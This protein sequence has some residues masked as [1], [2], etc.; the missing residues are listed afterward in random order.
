[1][2]AGS[3]ELCSLLTATP[4]HRQPAQTIQ[5]EGSIGE[6][7]GE[8]N[9]G[10]PVSLKGLAFVVGEVESSEHAPDAFLD[11]Q[12]LA[13]LRLLGHT[14]PCN[15]YALHEVR[16]RSQIATPGARECLDAATC[17]A[18]A[19]RLPHQLQRIMRTASELL[20][21]T[22]ATPRRPSSNFAKN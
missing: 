3:D 18:G 17:E 4:L 16:L 21:E 12:Q 5:T 10:V 19:L 14:S 15:L 13:N 7:F 6:S 22:H 11:R 9:D 1:M 8:S 2:P 20:P